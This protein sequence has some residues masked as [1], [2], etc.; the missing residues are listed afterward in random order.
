MT[1]YTILSSGF[2]SGVQ[3]GDLSGTPFESISLNSDLYSQLPK[4]DN[5]A[6]NCQTNLTGT[7]SNPPIEHFL[8]SRFSNPSR[9]SAMIT[10]QFNQGFSDDA[11]LVIIET[12][13]TTY[14]NGRSG[15]VFNTLYLRFQRTY[16]WKEYLCRWF[17]SNKYRYTVEALKGHWDH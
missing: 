6:T 15:T 11:T 4:R 16:S 12:Y 8:V 3:E 10:D 17:S 13:P 7:I 2:N 9:V 5:I 1:S 14:F